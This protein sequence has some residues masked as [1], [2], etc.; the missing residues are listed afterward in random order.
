[1][2][3][4]TFNGHRYLEDYPGN[5][6]WNDKYRQ[7]LRKTNSFAECAQLAIEIIGKMPYPEKICQIC[8]P[9]S[10]GQNSFDQNIYNFAAA[11]NYFSI[12]N[13]NSTGLIAFDQLPFESIIQ[14][15]C[16]MNNHQDYPPVI[17]ELYQPIFESGLIKSFI[18]LPG[19]K[20]SVGAQKEHDIIVGQ[21]LP[22]SYWQEFR[23]AKLMPPIIRR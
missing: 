16:Q 1:M 7:Q 12:E 4:E 23:L 11:I 17:E 13:F 8:G 5:F 20:H 14:R 21:K 19:W 2:N 9:I 10:T 18:F 6:C 3:K 15:I 22:I